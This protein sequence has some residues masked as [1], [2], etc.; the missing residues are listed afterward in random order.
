MNLEEYRTVFVTGILVLTLIVAAPTVS[1]IVPFSRGG[2]RFSELWLLGPNHMAEDYPFNVR[3][4]ET[5]RVFVGISNHMGGSAYH[6]VYVKLRNQT[7]P[8]PNTTASE[9]SPLA[10]LYEFR[11]F[12]ADGDTWESPLKLIV[13]EV[14]RNDDSIFINRLAIND[15]VLV[16]NAS[17]RWDSEYEGFYFQL[18]LELWLYNM[19]TQ[20][21]QYHDRFVAIW[22]NMTVS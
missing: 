10:P 8:L 1:L 12:V 5:Y 18:F 15:A 7:E 11:A 14:S 3:V 20:S 21:F 17:S 22:L 19:T 9:P 2:E 6:L 4:N 13:L 16:V